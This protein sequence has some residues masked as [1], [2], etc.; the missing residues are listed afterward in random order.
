MKLF[1]TATTSVTMNE[2]EADIIMV[3]FIPLTMQS[4]QCCLVLSNPNLGDVVILINATVA[5]PLPILPVSN[6]L[7][8]STH[9]NKVAKTLH[10]KATVGEVIKEDIL[11]QNSNN[12]FEAIILELSQ[13]EMRDD[14]R[15]KRTNTNSL[16]YASLRKAME[17]LNL[18]S[19]LKTHWDKMADR[20]SDEQHFTV[21]SDSNLFIVPSTISVPATKHGKVVFP[22]QF[23]CNIEGRF[24]CRIVLRSQYDVRVYRVEAMVMDRGRT[25]ELEIVTPALEPIIQTIPI[26]RIK[27][28]HVHVHV[29]NYMYMYVMSFL[30]NNYNL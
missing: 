21:E 26:V 27:W 4:R 8:S 2:K 25:A 29:H 22:I 30:Y 15:R 20:G 24:S 12:A 14:E 6:H 1:H 3:D 5:L 7:L 16:Q 18:D 13:W 17:A 11:I 9:V 19:S 23:S 10:L 28:W